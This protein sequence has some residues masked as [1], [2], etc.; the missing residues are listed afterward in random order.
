MIRHLRD[1]PGR[2]FVCLDTD[3]VDLPAITGGTQI[4]VYVPAK[5][6]VCEASFEF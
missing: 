1:E 4:G 2:V 3:M 5:V 6:T